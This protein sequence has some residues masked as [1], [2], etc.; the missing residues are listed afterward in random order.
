[1]ANKKS[2]FTQI[3][4]LLFFSIMFWYSL[5]FAGNVPKIVYQLSKNIFID[6]P[7]LNRGKLYLSSKEDISSMQIS[8]DCWATGKFIDKKDSLFTF[9]VIFTE[10]NC[11]NPNAKVYLKKWDQEVLA[12]FNVISSIDLYSQYLDLSDEKIREYLDW[13]VKTEE[14]LSAYNEYNPMMHTSYLDYLADNR[15]LS[16]VV[17]LKSFVSDILEKRQEKYLIPIRWLEMTTVASKLPNSWRP[18]RASYTDWIHE[19]WDFDTNFGTTVLAV[20]YW[21][22]VRVVKGFV[23]SDLDNIKYTGNLTPEDKMWNLDILRGNQVWIKTMKWDVVFYSH[24]DSI[25]EN[26]KE[27]DLVFR[28]QPLGKVWISWVPDQNYSDYHLHLEVRKNPYESTTTP[29]T[30]EDYMSWDWYFKWES[31]SYIKENQYSVFGKN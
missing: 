30:Y 1:M 17:Y 26:I 21:I 9:E 24:L 28:W 13:A 4:V 22:V 3:I 27:W 5:V 19:W 8:W 18:Y 31:E 6:S 15:R 23:F 11:T 29:Y 14:K 12:S 20:D 2:I 7:T 10:E 16:E 25:Y